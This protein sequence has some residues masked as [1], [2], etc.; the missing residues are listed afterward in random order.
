[1]DEK[2]REKIRIVFKAFENNVYFSQMH[3]LNLIE[4]MH[5]LVN[6]QPSTNQIERVGEL[7]AAIR[8]Q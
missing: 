6:A 4:P 1:M 5:A 2:A 7:R 8:A 3:K